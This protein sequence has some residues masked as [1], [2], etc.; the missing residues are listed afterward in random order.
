MFFWDTIGKRM[1]N[2]NC[3]ISIDVLVG[4]WNLMCDVQHGGT[5]FL[6]HWLIVC[7]VR[8]GDT[9]FLIHWLIVFGMGIHLFL[10]KK[11]NET[12]D[13]SFSINS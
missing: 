2:I 4:M 12:L 11:K 13:N 6:I 8:H 7:D 3:E 1:D 5:P 10:K 9:P